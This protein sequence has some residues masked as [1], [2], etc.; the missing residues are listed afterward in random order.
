[1]AVS[2]RCTQCR[3]VKQLDLFPLDK[4]RKNGHQQPCRQCQYQATRRWKARVDYKRLRRNARRIS[5]GWR[6]QK[7][8]GSCARGS[9]G[10]KPPSAPR[11]MHF[12]SKFAW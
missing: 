4:R 3:A 2:L 6:I 1:M 8:R 7:A 12:A 10:T 9:T 5:K 11:L